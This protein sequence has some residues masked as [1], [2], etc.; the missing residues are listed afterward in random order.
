MSFSDIKT[1]EYFDVNDIYII[2]GYLLYGNANK[3]NNIVNQYIA[4]L[5]VGSCYQNGTPVKQLSELSNNGTIIGAETLENV[6]IDFIYNYPHCLIPGFFPEIGGKYKID[7]DYYNLQTVLDENKIC[8][9]LGTATGEVS[10]YCVSKVCR[11]AIGNLAINNV[12]NFDNNGFIEASFFTVLSFT[13]YSS[14]LQNINEPESNVSSGE[15]MS[16]FDWQSEFGVSVLNGTNSFPYFAWGGSR[17]GTNQPRNFQFLQNS[18]YNFPAFSLIQS[19]YYNPIGLIYSGQGVQVNS[20]PIATLDR[21]LTFE[22]RNNKTYQIPISNSF[23]EIRQVS[24]VSYQAGR[25]SYDYFT[26]QIVYNNRNGL[27]DLAFINALIGAEGAIPG[28]NNSFFGISLTDYWTKTLNLNNILAGSKNNT[29]VRNNPNTINKASHNAPLCYTPENSETNTENP[30]PWNPQFAYIGQSGS[31]S[32]DISS[33]NAHVLKEGITTMVISGAYPLYR[34]AWS[35]V[36]GGPFDFFAKGNGS[37]FKDQYYTTEE[38]WRPI[39]TD[40]ATAQLQAINQAPPIPPNPPYRIKGGRIVLFEGQRV[41]AGSYVYATIN[42]CGNVTMPQYIPPGAK[43]IIL[44]EGE[45]DQITSDIYSKNQSNQGGLIVMVITDGEDPP[46]PPSCAVP[47]GI[48]L[49]TIEGFGN[50]NYF[51][52]DETQ[53]LEYSARYGGITLPANT[54]FGDIFSD[55]GLV[56]PLTQLNVTQENVNHIQS[57]EI[58]IRFFPM[59]PSTSLTG[60]STNWLY[61]IVAFSNCINVVVGDLNKTSFPFGDTENSVS[62]QPLMTKI[63]TNYYLPPTSTIFS[64]DL[65]EGISFNWGFK[66]KQF[67]N[68]YPYFP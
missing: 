47:V 23:E 14:T 53:N 68:D 42:T 52:N 36:W 43:E 18:L 21:K 17:L 1:F 48:V 9:I 22:E 39:F 35:D 50:P 6:S 5:R 61:F 10:T 51:D 30:L 13:D 20:F 29:D 24:L 37:I 33:S 2:D 31:N 67:R 62:F 57:R 16:Y 60:V 7:Q 65:L 66:G 45:R 49:E 59:T 28:R 38:F 58:L 27:V 54:I 56:F 3:P 4:T 8:K 12:L 64:L 15:Y 34:G 26:N 46:M 25:G 19:K 44:N 32:S 55:G 11:S 40:P 63:K 41:N